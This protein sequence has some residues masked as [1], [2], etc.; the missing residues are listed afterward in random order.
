MPPI[1]LILLLYFLLNL[2]M[3]AFRPVRLAWKD[4]LLIFKMGLVER[5]L[6]SEVFVLPGTNPPWWKKIV[7]ALLF[8]SVYL[9][10]FIVLVLM[11]VFPVPQYYHAIHNRKHLLDLWNREKCN[12]LAVDDYFERHLRK[13]QA[14]RELANRIPSWEKW[15][16][17]TDQSFVEF[18][19]ELPFKPSAYEIFYVEDEY[20]PVVNDYILRHYDEICELFLS[21]C[22][23]FNYLPKIC[24]Q[25]IPEAVLRYMCP[26][27][28]QIYTIENGGITMDTLRKHLVKGDFVGPALIH[29]R[30]NDQNSPEKYYF[31]YRSLVPDSPVSLPKQFEWYVHH[32]SFAILG[33]DRVLRCINSVEKDE[34]ADVGFSNECFDPFTASTEW[35]LI[36]E[37][38]ERVFALR[39]RG[40][41]LHWIQKMIEMPPKLSR[42]VVDKEFRI[43][44]PDYNNMEITMS[45]LPKAVYLLFLKHPEGILFKQL[46]D[47]Y[48]ELLDIYKQVGNRVV[49][50]AIE[51]SIR[52]ITD[53]TKNSINEKCARIREAFISK[54]DTFYAQHYYIT[55]QRGEPKKI[56]LPR[57]LVDLQAL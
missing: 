18:D 13:Y 33:W 48:T 6:W 40:L 1:L 14:E 56:S 23:T 44:L 41:Q 24:H 45:P 11:L 43:F 37:I 31:S 51:K 42:L 3:L 52:D 12:D 2:A 4:L 36:D 19:T 39:K 10:L 9:L 54:F 5:N 22:L 57:D 16:A 35:D 30:H 46:S 28:D 34:N 38:R 55:G 21:Q 32:V 47:Y 53:P 15:G 7:F 26:F 25:E 49:E 20:N 29:Y 50:S 8:A 17:K 27:L